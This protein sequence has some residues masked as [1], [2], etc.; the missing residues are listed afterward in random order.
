M[1]DKGTRHHVFEQRSSQAAV[2]RTHGDSLEVKVAV[3]VL[4][5]L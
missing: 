3:L 4:R 2:R 1:V 5:S